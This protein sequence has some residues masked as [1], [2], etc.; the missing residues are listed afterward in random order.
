MKECIMQKHLK[1]VPPFANLEGAQY[2]RLT[3]YRKDGEPVHTHVFF[4]QEDEHLYVTT[5]LDAGK[6]KRIRQNAQVEVAP[7]DKQGVLTGPVVEGAARMLNE[8][9]GKFANQA[10]THKYGI[11][12]R[13]FTLKHQMTG[14]HMVFLEI[15]PM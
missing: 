12:K 11:R 10:L 14:G 13:L 5:R 9:E 2:M 7:C 1:N 6:V 3:T 8:V 4:A 15:M